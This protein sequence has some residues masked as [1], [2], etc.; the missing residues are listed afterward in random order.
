M[1]TCPKCKHDFSEIDQPCKNCKGGRF[2]WKFKDGTTVYVDPFLSNIN[3]Q[4]QPYKQTPCKRCN[5]NGV[6][7]SAAN[8]NNRS[9]GSSNEYKACN[10]FIEWWKKPDGGAYEFKRT[11][12]SGGSDLA[13]GWDMAGDVCTN[14]PDFPFSVECK[15]DQGWNLEQLINPT[16][17][18]MG[19]F[20]EQALS[21]CPPHRIS[22][23]WLMHPGP[24]QPTFILLLRKGGDSAAKIFLDH[25]HFRAAGTFQGWRKLQDTTQSNVHYT[26][27]SL[28]HFLALDPQ[29]YRDH[30]INY[31]TARKQNAKFSQDAAGLIA[32][33]GDQND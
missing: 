23:L 2:Q 3:A 4:V 18:R 32:R 14:A 16:G 21:D 33:L 31:L 26:I 17:T 22:L 10:T 6:E 12:Q 15:R 19:E 20:M 1:I 13:I 25:K 5:G 8:R 9:R 29:V 28:K 24:S 30:Y 27:M 7:R 11:P